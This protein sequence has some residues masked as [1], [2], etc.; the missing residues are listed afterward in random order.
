MRTQD[1]KKIQM[2]Q[3]LSRLGFEPASEKPGDIWYT[4]P[5]R[6][7]E[8]KA[9]FH[10]REKDNVWYDFGLGSGG[11]V[12][13]FVMKY[14]ELPDLSSA[15]RKLDDMQGW[16]RSE[17]A[18]Q[19]RAAQSASS[20]VLVATSRSEGSK[21]QT[22]K[23]QPL[24]H[25][26]LLDY[27][28]KRGIDVAVARTH[29]QEI[30][31]KTRTNPDRTFFALAF[32]NRMANGSEHYEMRSAYFQGVQGQKDLSLILPPQ[33]EQAT[34]VRVF[35]G[36][37]DF[38]SYLTWQEKRQPDTAVIVLNGVG[39]GERAI[40][41]I[42]ESGMNEVHLCLDQDTAG[43]ELT[44]KFQQELEDRRVIDDSAQYL[45]YKDFNEFLQQKRQMR[46]A[47]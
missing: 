12:I 13:D 4:S 18:T 43:R 16:Q 25:W 45:G 33:Q 9:S 34:T 14:F 10:V 28:K 26:G 20:Q 19:P 38:L 44:A 22:V 15:L 29:L 23:I 37:M 24:Q 46:L 32:P 47:L 41:L 1:A 11:N 27:V 21:M 6:P 42:R 2:R 35:E 30:Y 17:Q 5:F 40:T 36:F 39:M 8:Q 3:L 7:Q 31:Y